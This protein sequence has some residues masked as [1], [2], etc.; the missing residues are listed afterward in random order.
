MAQSAPP[1]NPQ[2]SDWIPLGVFAFVHQE[3]STPKYTMQLAV[4]KSGATCWQLLRFDFRSGTARFKVRWTRNTQRVAWTVGNN[5]NTVGETGLA[6]LTQDEAPV[7]MHIGPIKRSNGCWCDCP[8]TAGP[9]A[10]LIVCKSVRSSLRELKEHCNEIFL[11][12][13]SCYLRS[14]WRPVRLL[15]SDRYN[16]A[17]SRVQM[18]KKLLPQAPIKPPARRVRP[19]PPPPSAAS[20]FR[21]PIRNSAV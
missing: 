7:L 15:V 21:R 1:P 6:N 13:T 8:T 18:I 16:S 12:N 4:N 17:P 11:E 20:N 2:S 5:K 3:Q 10:R 9:A 14:P 19:A